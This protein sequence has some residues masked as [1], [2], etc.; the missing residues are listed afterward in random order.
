MVEVPCSHSVPDICPFLLSP[1]RFSQWSLTKAGEA[2]PRQGWLHT[3]HRAPQTPC[4]PG[5]GWRCCSTRSWA[6]PPDSPAPPP[7]TPGWEQSPSHQECSKASQ[8]KKEE[9]ILLTQEKGFFFILV[10]AAGEQATGEVSAWVVAASLFSPSLVLKGKIRVCRGFQIAF[11]AWYN[12]KGWQ[13]SFPNANF[14][15]SSKCMIFRWLY[16]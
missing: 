9:M 16:I 8:K 2:V 1:H 10:A 5:P 6:L 11:S 13:A 4:A 3:E 12:D 14:L 15:F 7:P